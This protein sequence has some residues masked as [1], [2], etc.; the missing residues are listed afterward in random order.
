MNFETLPNE[1][2]ALLLKKKVDTYL[3][4]LGIQVDLIKQVEALRTEIQKIV[5]E[6]ENRDGK[7]RHTDATG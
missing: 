3:Q 4:S 7:D 6:I 5:E 1:E 2:L